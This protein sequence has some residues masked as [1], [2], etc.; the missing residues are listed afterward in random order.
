MRPSLDT[1]WDIPTTLNVTLTANSQACCVPPLHPCVDGECLA[2]TEVCRD[3]VD[4][5][6]GNTGALPA[7]IGY[8]S[9][10]AI[11]TYGDRPYGGNIDIYGTTDCMSGVDYYEFEWTTTPLN[12]ASW[13]AMPPAA[14]GDFDRTYL[15]SRRSASTVRRSRRSCRSTDGMSTRRSST[16]RRTTFR[17]TGPAA[18]ACGWA[19][20]ATC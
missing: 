12:P 9:P 3:V 7:P 14:S 18:I 6:G 4:T 20:R 11:S 2:I 19:R 15:S 16:T 10:G 13:A 17:P 8:K 1:R 5:I